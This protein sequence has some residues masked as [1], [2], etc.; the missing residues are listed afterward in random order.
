MGAA[1]GHS[2]GNLR[3]CNSHTIRRYII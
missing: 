1:H 2:R 3:S